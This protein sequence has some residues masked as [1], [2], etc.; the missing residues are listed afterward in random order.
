[1]RFREYV[2]MGLI[3]LLLFLLCIV[4][5]T[6]FT[7]DLGRHLTLGKIIIEG[8][9]VPHT[10]LFSYTYPTYE[11]INHHWLSEVI[12]FV[13]FQIYS[14]SL[15]ILKGLIFLAVVGISVMGGKKN[16][17]WTA[18]GLSIL[19][20]LPFILN[21]NTIRPELFGYLGFS[22]LLL[23]VVQ[24]SIFKKHIW[25][26]PILMLLWINM[27]VSFVFGL[28][29]LGFLGVQI[30]LRGDKRKTKLKML[31]WI[32]FGGVVLFLNPN[33]LQ[34]VFQPFT[35]FRN[36]G[37]EIMENQSLFFTA[38]ITPSIFVWYAVGYSA[39]T[40]LMGGMLFFL[41]KYVLSILVFLFYALSFFQVRHFPF[42]GIIC[43]PA[44]A[45]MIEF[46]INKINKKRKVV[47][48]FGTGLASAIIL[49][50]MIGLITNLWYRMYDSSQ[51]FGLGYQDA[52]IASIEFMKKNNLPPHV[53]NNFDIGGYFIYHLYPKYKPFIDNRPEAYPKTFIQNEYIALQ[54]DDDIRKKMFQKY[55]I[56]TVFFTHTD[57]TPWGQ[58]FLKNIMSDPSWK[59]VYVDSYIIILTDNTSFTD[60]RSQLSFADSLIYLQKD[61][62][63]VLRLLSL[64]SRMQAYPIQQNAVF[65]YAL[66][67]NPNSCLVRKLL[68]QNYK[69]QIELYPRAVNLEHDSWFCFY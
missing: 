6:D 30:M 58:I 43:I 42:F 66:E 22:I 20:S 17:S 49:I 52:G 45:L 31:S 47:E 53:F 3:F 14:S 48:V 35:I 33:G 60:V 39:V 19:L 37:Y 50:I 5:S 27:H 11:F 1:M 67:L 59:V 10:N 9:S 15:I 12:F 68:I 23:F 41:K 4:T 8:R 69:Q 51:S 26:I 40:L 46:I 57:Q 7:Q 55:D 54:T 65:S 2:F 21:R 13:L 28:L 63:A 62:L 32:L 38:S 61:S 16:T 29:L 34:G 44:G 18:V 36:Y 56:H 25:T 64:F 24:E